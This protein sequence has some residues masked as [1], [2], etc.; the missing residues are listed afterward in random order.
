MRFRSKSACLVALA[1][2]LTGCALDDGDP[3]GQAQFELQADFDPS[4]RLEEGRIQTAKN[5]AV[6][7]ETIAV[8][9]SALSLSMRA[10]GSQI[11]FDP[12]DPPAGFSLC[13]NGH[14]HSDAG[15]LVDYE[16]I[17]AGL[18]TESTTTGGVVQAIDT[19]VELAGETRVP[20]DDCSNECR[21]ERGQL[22]TVSLDI[23]SLRLVGRAFDTTNQGRL[24]EEGIAF[25]QLVPVNVEFTAVVQ[26]LVGDG[27]PV[28]VDINTRIQIS[29]KLFD[30]LEFG[31]LVAVPLSGAAEM[32]ALSTALREDSEFTVE[33][34]R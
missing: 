3:W 23:R 15:E 26:G 20:L 34:N 14:C 30:P 28:D 2:A 32:A 5:Y 8:G 22:N 9:F 7:L 27:E 6:D 18:A 31:D 24:P 17:A 16:D 33:V 12:A 21:V 11:D 4:S 13:H 10:D 25:D 19:E 1:L 29:E